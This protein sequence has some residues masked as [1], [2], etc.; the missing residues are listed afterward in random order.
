MRKKLFVGIAVFAMVFSTCMTGYAQSVVI[1]GSATVACPACNK[2]DP[3]HIPAGR[4][5]TLTQGQTAQ[6]TIFDWDATYGYCEQGGGATATNNA[7]LRNCKAVFDLC[8]CEPDACDFQVGWVIGIQMKILEPGVYFAGDANLVPFP[9]QTG[10]NNNC[11]SDNTYEL[12]FK[13]FREGTTGTAGYYPT[14]T[15]ADGVP[16]ANWDTM[17]VSYY[18]NE[19]AA[20]AGNPMTGPGTSGATIIRTPTP[21]DGWEI[22]PADAAQNLC[23]WWFDMPA[24]IA[25]GA[26]TPGNH[27]NVELSLF[28]AEPLTTDAAGYADRSYLRSNPVLTGGT[29]TASPDWAMGTPPY[30]VQGQYW[31]HDGNIGVAPGPFDCYDKE[32]PLYISNTA[33]PGYLGQA[34][35]DPDQ[36]L[37][38]GTG[39][40]LWTWRGDEQIC[41]RCKICKCVIDVG[42]LCCD[43]A[44]GAFCLLF[45]YVLQGLDEWSTGIGLSTLC[46]PA[47]GLTPSVTLTL[48]DCQG[49]AF[50]HT[51]SPFGNCLGNGGMT[52]DQMVSE[53]GWT[54]AAGQ[55]WLKVTSNVVVDGYQFNMYNANGLVFGA[56]VLGEACWA[57]CLRGNAD[58]KFTK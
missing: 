26:I 28:V 27:V 50:N 25:S 41:S 5:A 12:R 30:D 51:I 2:C 55:G 57:G 54:P 13:R 16:M 42:I 37:L 40:C 38:A 9:A 18:A 49:A 52:I 36:T 53:Y 47:A 1:G 4:C 35:C 31:L 48:T 34:P 56:G 14:S 39:A 22:S 29:A 10:V 8:N 58:T 11:Y 7:A 32:A 46:T 15:C 43:A 23:E 45:P 3:W 17:K 19:A 44:E 24:M 6:N 20:D 33:D 21:Y